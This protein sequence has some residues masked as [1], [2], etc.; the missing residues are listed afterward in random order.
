MNT[1]KIWTAF[2]VHRQST[3]EISRRTGEPEC[4]VD[5]I[6]ARCMDCHYY[7]KPMPFERVVA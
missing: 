1:R 2:I 5:R 7:G 3:A 6:I 4:D